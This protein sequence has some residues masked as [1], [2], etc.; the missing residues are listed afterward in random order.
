MWSNRSR[1]NSSLGDLC[2]T[3]EVLESL[4]MKT[5]GFVGAV[6]MFCTAV[7][8]GNKTT[9]SVGTL[10]LGCY[11]LKHDCFGC[12]HAHVGSWLFYQ[13]LIDVY[14]PTEIDRCRKIYDQTYRQVTQLLPCSILAANKK[15]LTSTLSLRLFFG[16]LSEQSKRLKIEQTEAGNLK[17]STK[18]YT[19]AQIR[20]RLQ[21]VHNCTGS[22]SVT[23]SS[24]LFHPVA[25]GVYQFRLCCG[26]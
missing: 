12:V 23:S 24:S 3:I 19:I 20:N 18:M 10:I 6:T 9:I 11:S 17:V 14:P 2:S 7:M 22:S 26:C 16:T 4:M 15:P 5:D 1:S 21:A 8:S 13:S 25:V